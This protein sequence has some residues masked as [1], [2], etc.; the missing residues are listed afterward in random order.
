MCDRLATC[1]CVS[2]L[3]SY[4]DWDRLQPLPATLNFIDG[5]KW[6]DRTEIYGANL[7]SVYPIDVKIF[8]SKQKCQPHCGA[9]QK[10]SSQDHV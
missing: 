7:M 6:M 4:D 3:W 2:C 10:S 5:R 9:G 1:R 8:H